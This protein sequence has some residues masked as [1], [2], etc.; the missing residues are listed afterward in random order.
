MLLPHLDTCALGPLFDLLLESDDRHTRRA[1]FDRL[2]RTGRRGAVGALARLADDRWYVLRN[3]LAL[4]AEIDD[5]PPALD[6][7]P[8]L[9]NADARVRR[10][11]LRVALRLDG[12]RD[13]A[14][15]AALGDS[16]D[17]VRLAA[18]KAVSAHPL[19]SA[20]PRLIGLARQ[21][22]LDDTLRAAA[23][24]ALVRVSRNAETRDLLLEVAAHDT[25]RLRWAPHEA[26]GQVVV[27]A[28]AALAAHWPHD[29][30]VVPILR[31]AAASRDPGIRLAA[32][33]AR[34]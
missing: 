5:L 24:D 10:E 8:W 17:R 21:D 12:A 33:E 1:V 22:S 19:V 18:I 16:D 25:R 4:L 34:T 28:L 14:V 29:P 2:R 23:L 20:A 9:G 31:R 6:P 26:G 30:R 11:A 13:R 15:W 7:T 32:T 3:L 27:T